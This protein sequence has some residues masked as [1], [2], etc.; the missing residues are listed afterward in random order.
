MRENNGKWICAALAVLSMFAASTCLAQ[1]D[2]GVRPGPAG[3]GLPLPGLTDIELALFNEGIQ[4]AIQL[5]AA[6]DDCAD[7]VLGSITDP[8]H[9]SQR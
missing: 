3:G 2:P 6:C 5:E 4:R 9:P 7:L 1:K 8:Q